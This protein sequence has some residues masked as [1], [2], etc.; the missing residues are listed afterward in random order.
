MK[1]NV[2]LSSDS[3]EDAIKKLEAYSKRIEKNTE[4]LR[5]RI[6]HELVE[7]IQRGFDESMYDYQILKGGSQ[8]AEKP[9]VNVS[10]NEDGTV[11]IASGQ[12]A[13]FVE[14][15][16]G[17]Y[18]NTAVGSSPHPNGSQFGLTIGSYGS[19]GAKKVWGYY[20]DD[21]TLHLTRGTPAQMPMY[22][23]T[24]E[25]CRRITDIAKEIFSSD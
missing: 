13:V 7:E 5:K 24:Q 11:V 15:G 1:I 6:A 4:L 25:V 17:V 21:G 19:N 23:A 3:I 10:C 2:S 16:A 22:N 18:F 14:F 12:E 9:Q 20:D 8:E